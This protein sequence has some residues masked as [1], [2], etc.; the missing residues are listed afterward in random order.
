M[1]MS[2]NKDIRLLMCLLL[3]AWGLCAS[4]QPKLT[5]VSDVVNVGDVMFQQPKS[6]SFEIRNSG[7]QPLQLTEVHASCGCTHVIWPR[8]PIAPGESA[9]IEALYDAMLLGTF[10][11]ELEVYS[12]ASAEPTYLTLQ[13]RVVSTMEETDY[14]DFPIDLGNVRLS[15]NVVEFDDVSRGEQPVVQLQ[16]VNM[17]R[18][19]YKPEIMH[20]P[21]YLT[22]R[23]LP[24]KLAGG[25]VGRI[26]LTLNT[27]E[28]KNYGLTETTVYLA[29]K[30][31]DR[32]STEN[33]I[34]VSA[35][36]LPAFA[37]LS[38]E[39]MA[40]G[41]RMVLS[42]DSLDFG[43]LGSKKKVTQTI[44]VTNEG[45]RPLTISNVQ[46]YGS[47]LNVSLSSRII[48][49]GK[50]A[51]LKVTVLKEYLQKT[52]SRP[53]VLIIAD[54]PTRPKAVINIKAKP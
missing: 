43:A 35:V 52:K 33:E 11:K 15:S 40:A 18:S 26:L 4:A 42:A 10:Q 48:Q 20:L 2:Y 50:S 5:V 36:L 30:V 3:A 13:G 24:E 53:R 17:S 38:A 14:T 6:I 1:F 32:V 51:K 22:A 21:P 8:E 54:D 28:L 25:R 29:R 27:E 45:Q 34:S 16:V 7:S 47:A 44:K 39:D 19:S 9:K 46:V 37:H 41:P 12:N 23:Y 49:P 31:G